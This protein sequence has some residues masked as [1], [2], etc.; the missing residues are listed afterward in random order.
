MTVSIHEPINSQQLLLHSR[1][2]LSTNTDAFSHRISAIAQQQKRRVEA[3]EE[4]RKILMML[5]GKQ[6][7]R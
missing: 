6:L 1:H 3:D 2:F 4:K 5:H 7:K